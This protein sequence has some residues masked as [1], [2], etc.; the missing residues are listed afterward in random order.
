MKSTVRSSIMMVEMAF[1]CL[2]MR[3]NEGAIV[4]NEDVSERQYQYLK[5]TIPEWRLLVDHRD[6]LK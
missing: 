3:Q 5:A 4:V 6:V 2:R 1:R